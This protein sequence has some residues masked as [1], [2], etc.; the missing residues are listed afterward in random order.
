MRLLITCQL[1][2]L[3]LVAANSTASAFTYV[4]YIVLGAGPGGLQFAHYLESAGRDYLVL[5]RNALSASFFEQYPRWRQL[6][7]I[8]KRSVGRNN[9]LDFAMR[10][11]WNSLLSE[12]SHSQKGDVQITSST[13]KRLDVP[14][15]D[16]VLRFTAWSKDYF[17]NADA[18]REYMQAWAAAPGINS[19]GP[20][21][22][23]L[24]RSRPLRIRY[25]A[26]VTRVGRPAH[27]AANVTVHGAPRFVVTLGSGEL[28]TCT[29]LIV[30]TGLQEAVPMPGTNGS[31]A[32]V[33]GLVHT[34]STAPAE[35]VAYADKR[36]LLLGN[37]NAAFEFAHHVL[38]EAAYVHIAG[39]PT[40]RLKLALET[41]YPGNVRLVHAAALETYNLKSLDGLTSTSFERLEFSAAP[42]GGVIVS[43]AA[44]PCAFDDHGRSTS[45]C[46][47]RH[48]Y[49]IVIACL[50]WRF[51]RNVFDDTATP[52]L[53]LNGKH[54]AMTPRYESTNVTGMYFA[55]G[56]AHAADFKKSSGGFIHGFRYTARALHRII[57]EE[58]ADAAYSY[59]ISGGGPVA[60]IGAEGDTSI[61]ESFGALSA[62]GSHARWPVTRTNTL[63][64][65]VALLLRRINNAAGLFQMFGSLV[66]LYILD[67]V[68]PADVAAYAGP[69]LHAAMH[70]PAEF[71]DFSAINATRDHTDP[72]GIAAD[73]VAMQSSVPPAVGALS[74]V[75]RAS[76]AAIDAALAGGLREEVPIALTATAAHS[77]AAMQKHRSTHIPGIAAQSAEWLTLSL[78][79]GQSLPP[80]QKDPFALDRA[81]VSLAHPERSRFL[82]PVVRYFDATTSGCD[83]SDGNGSAQGRQTCTPVATLHLIE[84]FHASWTLHNAHVLPL[85]RFL[86][87]LGARRATAALARR[88]GPRYVPW[89]PVAPPPPP[90]LIGVV[91]QLQ[92]GCDRASLFWRGAGFDATSGE[93]GWWLKLSIDTEASLSGLKVLAV[94]A[95]DWTA[96]GVPL[97]DGEAAFTRS[98]KEKWAAVK[99]REAMVSAGRE[100]SIPLPEELP[101]PPLPVINRAQL[102]KAQAAFNEAYSAYS[103]L[104]RTSVGLAVL[105]VDARAGRCRALVDNLHVTF[106]GVRVFYPRSAGSGEDNTKGVAVDIER[107]PLSPTTAVHHIHKIFTSLVGQPR[108]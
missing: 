6:I 3:L 1:L 70:F 28:Y 79:F 32:V 59:S 23:G 7:S 39:R 14:S 19:S 20:L 95:V 31:A 4:R 16:P 24:G 100:V 45:R 91:T 92:S 72:T 46:S 82:H 44:A 43:A 17:P 85:A 97:T 102:M 108:R 73:V 12:A 86:Q 81:D 48:P 65:L 89:L 105:V 26:D 22:V 50:G 38:G 30:A 34:Y 27:W 107:S 88:S 84:D 64:A 55:G 25:S 33:A 63:R 51:S 13:D 58:E 36:V 5:E 71:V 87:H 62:I 40:S 61:D 75:S 66:D 29:F 9:S 18:L 68:N 41:H 54:P 42:S 76:Q 10:H 56:L 106:G 57:E 78:E 77:W 74:D 2:K 35:G 101:R 52:A 15:I 69:G 49:D 99:A 103:S 37:G 104:T 8:N 83:D 60:D 93:E 11:D 53:A 80:G 21:P 96:P 67:T 98:V 90:F 94:H 47:F